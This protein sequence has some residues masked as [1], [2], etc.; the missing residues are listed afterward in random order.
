MARLTQVTD[1]DASPAAGQIF[2][3]L[4][5][6]IGMVPNVYRVVANQPAALSGLLKLGEELGHGSFD[7][8]TR[9][10]IALAVAGANDCDY[11]ASAHTAVSKNLKV[12]DAEIAARLRGKSA[13]PRIQAI[14]AFAVALAEKRGFVSDGDLQAARTAGLSDADI[15]ETIA[16]VVANIFTNYINHVAETDIDFPTVKAAAA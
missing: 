4:K 2:A 10:A 7:P 12:E 13:D 6:K 5:G 15:V 16:N 8:R 1:Q 14:L 3:A 11:C 9:E